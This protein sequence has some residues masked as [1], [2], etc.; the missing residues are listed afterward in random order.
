MT[1]SGSQRLALRAQPGKRQW[2]SRCRMKRRM[3]ALGR[4]A[5]VLVSITTPVCSSSRTRAMRVSNRSRICLL[6]TSD[7]ADDLT[8]VDLGG[9]RI[10]KKKKNKDE[11][12]KI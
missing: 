11:N 4:Y 6:Y 9:R 7:A 8:R 12:K 1:W 10:I 5:V 3:A 2:P